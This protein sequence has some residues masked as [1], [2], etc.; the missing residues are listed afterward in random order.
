[1]NLVEQWVSVSHENAGSFHLTSYFVSAPTGPVRLNM[2]LIREL[3]REDLSMCIVPYQ[4]R[5]VILCNLD[6]AERSGFFQRLS[7]LWQ[8]PFRPAAMLQSSEEGQRYAL[9]L[10]DN[11]DCSISAL[12]GAKNACMIA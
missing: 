8:R 9:S 7:A 6:L 1:M 5:I 10:S 12:T 11:T 4:G 2:H 3:T